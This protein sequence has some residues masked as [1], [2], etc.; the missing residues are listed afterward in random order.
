M[1]NGIGKLLRLLAEV[2]L[3]L[4]FCVWPAGAEGGAAAETTAVENPAGT[5]AEETVPH[6]KEDG[7]RFRLAY[8]DYD[9][10]LPASRQLYYILA[11][12]EELGWIREGALPFTIEEIDRENLATRE[13][14][15]R[16]EE[17]DLG[18]YL[19]F[20][21]DA[22]FYLGYE[23]EEEIASALKE[24]AEKDVDLVITFGTSAGVLV[25][26]LG[27]PIPMLD[28]SAT[29]PVTSGIIASSTEGSGNPNVWA[30][31][32]PSVPLRQLKY[33]YSIKPFKK[34]GVI[35]YGDE[36]ISGVPDIEASSR[37]IGFE[38]VKYNIEEQPRETAE[39][40]EAYYAMVDEQFRKMVEEG[41]DA[42]FL[43]IDLVNDLDRLPGYLDYFYEKGIPV[44]S[45]DDLETVRNGCLLLILANDQE[46]VGRFVADAMA[47]TLNGKIAGDLPCIYT[48]APGIYFNYDIARRIGYPMPIEFLTVCDQ[49]ITEEA[50][51]GQE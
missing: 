27:L 16:L 12:L 3:V 2:S 35:I 40:L 15:D 31:V 21:R 39:E 34:L 30:N 19:E 28:F 6:T 7:S 41:I 38:L 1:R 51:N 23:D 10:Y 22:F 8:V 46:N 44:Y 18:P 20:A 26:G 13:M 9:E 47:K 4:A 11:G 14:Y 48:S 32:E 43:T 25:S 42:F 17:A 37:E 29:D 36:T 50:A 45:M 24:R 33:Y 49:I 5:A